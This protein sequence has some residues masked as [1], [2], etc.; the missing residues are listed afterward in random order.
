M[1]T[2]NDKSL[3]KQ[4][5]RVGRFHAIHPLITE[6]NDQRAKD[7]IEAM[8]TK[9]CLHPSNAVKRKVTP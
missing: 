7:I 3:L 5:L 4:M 2:D 1:F 8:G 9:W 6:H